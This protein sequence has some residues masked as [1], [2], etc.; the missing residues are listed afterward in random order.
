MYFLALF[1]E[2][3]CVFLSSNRHHDFY[4]LEKDKIPLNAV[5]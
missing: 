1:V 2:H 3:V 5:C 4:F